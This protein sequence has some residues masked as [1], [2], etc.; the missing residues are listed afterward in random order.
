MNNK[1]AILIECDPHTTLGG[2]CLRDVRNMATHIIDRCSFTS[3]NIH[4]LTTQHHDK[5]KG[6]SY[7]N[8]N[9]KSSRT[10]IFNVYDNI[11]NC[12]PSQIVI[13]ISGHGFSVRDNNNDEI[14]GKDE[15]I[16]VGR[17]ITDDELYD[18]I[19]K[20]CP[21]E[22][23]L[24]I[25]TDTCH[26]G[27]MFDLNYCYQGN[28]KWKKSTKR[29]ANTNSSSKIISISA[30]NDSQLSMC[31]IG[32][33]TGFGGSLTTAVLNLPTILEDILHMNDIENA[34]E[35]VRDSLKLLHQT[36]ILSKM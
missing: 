31:D 3:N 9:Y 18:K 30:C 6:E 35:K 20:K 36:V 21:K 1:H 2:S 29:N 17:R 19:V 8:I 23:N 11:I 32:D 4:I 24:I 5:I 34:Y 25:F 22:C 33:T 14:D 10:D 15:Y 13:L 26:S 16:N 27:T 28:G 12:N 7:K